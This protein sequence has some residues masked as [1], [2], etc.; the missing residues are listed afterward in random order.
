MPPGTVFPVLRPYFLLARVPHAFALLSASLL[1]RMHQ[2][3]ISLVLTFLIAD[4]TGSYAAGGVV[5]GAIT[6]AQAVAAPLRG[7]AADRT[8]P[9]RVLVIT[10][11]GYGL[12][13]A[14]LAFLAGPE[15][16]LPAENWWLLVPVAAATGLSFPPAGQ[17][18][19]AMWLRI[20]DGPARRAAFA[21]EATAQELLFVIAPILA[22]FAVAAQGAFA[23]TLWCAAVGALGP[24]VFALVLRRAGITA[25]P[26]GERS[27]AARR[28][29][30]VPGFALALGFTCLMIAGVVA[31]D[32]LIVGW[33]RDRGA[34]ELAGYLAAVWAVGSLIGGLLLGAARG[35][36]RLWLRGALVATGL[37]AL[38]PVLPPVADP[39][40]PWVVGAVLLVGGLGIAPMFAANNA[41][42]GELAPDGRRAEAFGWLGS[43]GTA[44][45]ALAAPLT[46]ALLDVAGPAAAAATGA[47]L[48]FAAVCLAAHPNLRGSRPAPAAEDTAVT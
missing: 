18:G 16:W 9:G 12:G 44:G 4:R 7:R 31:V 20:A 36:P 29:L 19:R 6:V 28:L 26:A 1:A 48:A 40:S 45:A 17:V 10:G 22:A 27:R 3:A 30:A 43:A 13:L 8:G 5:G 46:G 41:Q 14:L 25:A 21:V 37:L 2:P 15:G 38:V 24:V 34:P 42:L 35:R 23:A 11:C 33:S 47:S 32:L 39:G